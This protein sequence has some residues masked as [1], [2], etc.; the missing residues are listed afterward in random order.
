[1]EITLVLMLESRKHN[2]IWYLTRAFEMPYV[3]AVGTRIGIA[4]GNFA[5]PSPVPVETVL[6]YPETGKIYLHLSANSQA[7]RMVY[8]RGGWTIEGDEGLFRQ[9]IA[10]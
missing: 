7:I 6:Y 10:A 9:D 4:G 1:M 8:E 3:P 5:L 2:P